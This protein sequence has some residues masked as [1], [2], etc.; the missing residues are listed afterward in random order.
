MFKLILQAKVTV[1]EDRYKSL[2]SKYIKKNKNIESRDLAY[3][4]F[5]LVSSGINENFDG[6][7]K[8]RI[9]ETYTTA[10]NKPLDILHLL[11]EEKSYLGSDY[12][13]Y[14]GKTVPKE[15]VNTIVGSIVES[16]IVDNNGNI[17]NEKQIE[18][19]K[20]NREFTTEDPIHIICLAGLYQY[21]FPKTI[22]RLKYLVN[23][24]KAFVSVEA[25]FTKWNYYLIESKEFVP[26]TD[27]TKFLDAQIGNTY[28]GNTVARILDDF[29][30]GGVGVTATPATP[31][32][33]IISMSNRNIA[34][35]LQSYLRIH[36]ILH[37]AYLYNA[38][39]SIEKSHLFITQKIKNLV[40]KT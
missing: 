20:N 3:L 21:I 24:D 17:L 5:I 8:Y 22:D 27:K 33:V 11:K 7:P 6:F 23:Q 9:A 16:A 35:E 32:S 31:D 30:I 12:D 13:I 4:E 37:S 14:F 38:D 34:D 18:E 1:L 40:G 39:E 19:V 26:R 29:I 15:N 10:I 2:A 36:D 28:E 25:Y